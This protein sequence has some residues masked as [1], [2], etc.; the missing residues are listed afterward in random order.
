M[1][2]F[3]LLLKYMIIFILTFMFLNS[4]NTITPQ[5]IPI[6]LFIFVSTITLDVFIFDNFIEL[7][8][9]KELM[10]SIDD[11]DDQKNEI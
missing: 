7:I 4:I 6:L 2:V 10:S 1:I 8:Q 11:I 5:I 3:H 9:K